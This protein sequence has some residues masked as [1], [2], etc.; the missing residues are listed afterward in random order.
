MGT[1][2]RR[3]KGTLGVFAFSR[4]LAGSGWEK[5][6]EILSPTLATITPYNFTL[7]SNRLSVTCDPRRS[8]NIG[9]D[10]TYHQQVHTI[11]KFLL[12]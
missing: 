5:G 12:T 2:R 1:L 6:R 8:D 4:G 3:G 9:H 10:E 11:G 7:C